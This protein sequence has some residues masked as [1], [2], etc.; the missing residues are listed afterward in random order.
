MSSRR[1]VQDATGVAETNDRGH[2]T[3]V[4]GATVPSDA[5]AGYAPGCIFQKTTGTVGATEYINEGSATSCD[6]NATQTLAG[7]ATQVLPAFTDLL[8]TSTE[9]NRTCDVSTRL[10]AAGA[11]LAVTVAAHDGKV[12]NL[13]TAA[14]S[15]CT[16]PTAAGTGAIFHFKIGTKAT[17]NSHI[18]K[19][20]TTD[21]MKGLITTVGD[22]ADK[23]LGWITAA[24]SDTITLNRTT[25]GSVTCGEWIECFD[26]ATG[27]WLVR[28]CTSSTGTEATP[29]S[30]TVS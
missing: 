11:T 24:D 28:G 3:R 10:I 25:T 16:L 12:I 26:L 4:L 13:D 6:F 8:A 7:L 17:S 19:V 21:I 30:A 18:I 22:D 27:V 14:G 9:I 23:V 1:H 29:F 2:I 5:T 15:V 20:T